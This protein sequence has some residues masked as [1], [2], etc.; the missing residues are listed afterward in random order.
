MA[1][2]GNSDRILFQHRWATRLCRENPWYRRSANRIIEVRVTEEEI[3]SRV[4]FPLLS[5]G[6]RD[7]AIKPCQISEVKHARYWGFPTVQVYYQEDRGELLCLEHA[8]TRLLPL[9]LVT[10]EGERYV[11]ALEEVM[12]SH[13]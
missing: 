8:F 12:N 11:Q 5:F 3:L 6:F 4:M 7:I 1:S 10:N 9:P 2:W 13:P